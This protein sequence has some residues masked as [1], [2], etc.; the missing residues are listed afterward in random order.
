MS[1]RTTKVD[2]YLVN[3][4][5]SPVTNTSFFVKPLRASFMSEY[6]GLSLDVEL[7][8]KTDSTGHVLADLVALPYPY[9]LIYDDSDDSNP[10]QFLFYVPAVD[11]TVNFQDLIVTRADSQ[12]KYVD[13]ALNQVING[14]AKC[15]QYS[16]VSQAASVAAKQAQEATE[17]QAQELA[18]KIQQTSQMLTEAQQALTDVQ[19]VKTDFD[20]T[21]ATISQAAG[22][23]QNSALTGKLPIGNYILW[24]DEDG[25][26][27]IS[28]KDAPS[29]DAGVV[30]G[31]Q[32]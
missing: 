27:R 9:V 28:S 4:D 21:N 18:P 14:V 11:F 23:I 17:T 10:G 30:V 8:L 13:N 6:A 19:Q 26:L 24:V 1:I 32:S 29:G 22:I 16:G 31:S 2:F 7:K 20:S 15:K 12:D 25:V 3:P 5:G